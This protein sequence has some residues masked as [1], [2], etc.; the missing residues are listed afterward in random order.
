M[1]HFYSWKA[2]AFCT[3]KEELRSASEP[4]VTNVNF[5][6]SGIMIYVI[7]GLAALV[8]ILVI[9]GIVWQR[10]FDRK[11]RSRRNRRF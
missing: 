4:T 10:H 11:Y 3:E 8:L 2:K 5:G 6:F 1:V 9:V 7:A